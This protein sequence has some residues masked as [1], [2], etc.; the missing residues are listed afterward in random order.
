[1]PDKSLQQL[2]EKRLLQDPQLSAFAI[3]VE[4]LNGIVT[5]RG[6]VPTARAKLAA[7]EVV[8]ATP[9]CRDVLNELQVDPAGGVPDHLVADEVRSALD[10][11]PLITKGTITVEVHAGCV[12]LGGAVGTPEEYNTADDLARSA[13]GVRTVHNLLLIDRGAQDDDESLQMEIEAALAEVPDLQDCDI[14]VAVSGDLVVLSGQV[15][16]HRH[17]QMAEEAALG[18][19]P[20]RLRNDIEVLSASHFR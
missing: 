9:G 17:R 6:A 14:K 19:R 7:H 5:L 15:R 2:I 4:T 1:L 8:Q 13:H 18:V 10:N 20:W 11:H 3:Q 16:D 12:T